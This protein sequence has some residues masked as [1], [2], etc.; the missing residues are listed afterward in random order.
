MARTPVNIIQVVMQHTYNYIN[1]S[2]LARDAHTHMRQYKI[3]MGFWRSVQTPSN[4]T[5]RVS[6]ESGFW[7]LR[8]LH[9]P[10]LEYI[11]WIH[12][13]CRLNRSWRQMELLLRMQ[14]YGQWNQW[15]SV[16]LYFVSSLKLSQWFRAVNQPITMK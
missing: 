12:Q 13:I 3:I 15:A 6:S 16:N 8:V 4:K 2:L 14:R 1:V 11:M 7:T 9:Q 10:W 5:S